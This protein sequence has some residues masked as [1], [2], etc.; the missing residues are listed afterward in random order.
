[1]GLL[2][3]LHLGIPCTG[4]ASMNQINGGTRSLLVPEGKDP[5]TWTPRLERVR[6]RE[7]KAN[8][9]ARY[10]AELFEVAFIGS[11]LWH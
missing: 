10:V 4:W 7:R 11:C 1:M 5:K 3:Y 9:Q 6:R 8:E 2:A